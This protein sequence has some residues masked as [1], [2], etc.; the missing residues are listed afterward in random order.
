MIKARV[1]LVNNDAINVSIGYWWRVVPKT[2]TKPPHV[3]K[4]A[5]VAMLSRIQRALCGDDFD[6]SGRR[7]ALACDEC[8][9]AVRKMETEGPAPPVTVGDAFFFPHPARRS[10]RRRRLRT[11]T[12]RKT[13]R[14]L[15]S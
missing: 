8:C 12:G 14:G 1:A 11:R 6:V 10:K 5:Y 4:E 3:T 15:T 7:R 13:P 2:D 9:C